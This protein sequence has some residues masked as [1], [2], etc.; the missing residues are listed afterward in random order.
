MHVLTRREI[1][2]SPDHWP[3]LNCT[4]NPLQDIFAAGLLLTPTL[5][6]KSNTRWLLPAPPALA[7]KLLHQAPCRSGGYLWQ[8]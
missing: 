7:A 5:T 4:S 8:L 3:L 1:N 6:E 2:T